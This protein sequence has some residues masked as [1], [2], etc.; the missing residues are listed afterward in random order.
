MS[1]PSTFV[2]SFTHAHRAF[3]CVRLEGDGE[4]AGTTAPQWIVTL[5]GRPVWSFDA[6][7]DDSPERVQQDVERWWDTS[8]R[9]ADGPPAAQSR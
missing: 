2:V 7:A 6:R 8:G 4:A 9:R 5:E 1:A 3:T